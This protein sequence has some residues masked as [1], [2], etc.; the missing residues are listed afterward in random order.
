MGLDISGPFPLTGGKWNKAIKEKLYWYGL[1]DHYSKKMLMNFGNNKSQIVIFVR[2]AHDFMKTRGTPIQTIRM[3]NSGENKEVEKIC[4]NELNIGVEY[5]PPDTPKL[6]GVVERGFAIRWEK[7]KILMQN[8]GLK[9]EVK[10][11]KKILI[12]AITMASY[13]VEECPQKGSVLSSNDL[14]FG[15]NQK[16][17]V[18]LHHCIEWGRLGFVPDKRTHTKKMDSRGKPMMMVGYALDHPSGTYEFY[19]PSTN[20]IIV[21]NS[22]KWNDFSRWEVSGSDSA[23]GQLLQEKSEVNESESDSDDDVFSDSPLVKKVRFN[24]DTNSQCDVNFGNS[25]NGND[26]HFGDE[27]SSTLGTNAG[28]I[29]SVGRSGSTDVQVSKEKVAK[30]QRALKK[31][32]TSPSYKVTGNVVPY[33]VF[34]RESKNDEAEINV[35]L[36]EEMMFSFRSVGGMVDHSDEDYLNEQLVMHMCIQSDPGEPTRWQD[37]FNGPEREWWLKST[38]AEFNN[39]LGR[40]AWKFVPLSEV[41]KRGR[42]LIPTK[43]VFKKKDEIDGSIRFKT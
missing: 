10:R 39:F 41:K 22:V 34:E 14:F 35:I 19:K 15:T 40:N 21:S 26:E 29:V 4:K 17:R 33:N 18:K 27:E 8:A 38:I 9:D 5:T 31:L 24:Q 23:I 1:S 28:A 43:L 32:S 7:A 6:N 20:N 13:L 11:R 37:A 30:V 25:N 36:T 16:N 42:K 3:D 2:Q 12:K